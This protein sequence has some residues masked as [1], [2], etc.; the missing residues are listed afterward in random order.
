MR[1]SKP[2][3]YDRA[4]FINCPFDDQYEPIFQAILFA[5]HASGF[6]ARCAKE[7]HS[8]RDRFTGIQE[9]IRDCK[10]G[11]HDVSNTSTTVIHGSPFPRFNMPLELG[12]FLGCREYGEDHL[13]DKVC[14][15]LDSDSHRHRYATSDLS[16]LDPRGHG[17]EPA[18]AIKEV[19]GWLAANNPAA[20]IAGATILNN[21]YSAFLNDLPLTCANLHKLPSELEYP[22][23]VNIL[24]QYLADKRY[25]RHGIP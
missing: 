17:N 25:Q 6:R 15:L 20:G 11:I 5:V 16:G 21:R 10:Y 9:L 8:G 14:L 24:V 22:E 7:F 19:A 3:D 23:L 13:A 1:F 12:L 18:R 2:V 4:V